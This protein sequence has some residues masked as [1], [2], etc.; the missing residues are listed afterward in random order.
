M[1]IEAKSPSRNPSQVTSL[2]ELVGAHPDALAAIYRAGQ[3]APPSSLG[4]RP[5]GRLLGVNLVPELFLAVRGAVRLF[6][7][8]KLPWQGKAFASDDTRGFNVVFGRH[9]MPFRVERAPSAIDGAETI[10]LRYDDPADRNPAPLRAVRD[11]MREVGPGVV[12]G[13]ILR[14]EAGASRV[15]GWW[16]LER[17]SCSSSE[18]RL[19]EAFK[20]PNRSRGARRL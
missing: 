19:S 15:I 8:D 20:N 18:V 17:R 2:D 3:V 13:P 5:R 14:D 10:V 4:L 16:G 1:S 12:M 11:E 7:T 6:A 9:V